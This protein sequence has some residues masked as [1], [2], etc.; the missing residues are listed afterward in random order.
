[1]SKFSF[2]SRIAAYFMV[3]TTLLTAG[4]YLV[5]YFVVHQT[6][7]NHL[8][9][10]LSAEAGEITS[11]I[12]ML[13]DRMILTNPYEWS[14][15]EHSQI[16]VNPTFIQLTDTTGKI[17]KKTPNLLDQSIPV[18]NLPENKSYFNDR[19]SGSPVRQLQVNLTN[20]ARKQFGTLTVAVPLEDSLLVLKNLRNTL[21]LSLPLVIFI[22]FFFTRFIAEKSIAPVNHLTTTAEKITRENLN[23]RI[24]LPVN[25][26][27]LYT[28]TKTINE[29]LDR[30]QDAVLREKQF[31]ADA[32]HELKTPLA[33]IRGMIEVMLRKPR[34]NEYY[35]NKIGYCLHEVN[36][37][38]TLVEQLLI[39]ARYESGAGA[40][41]RENIP[42]SELLDN[43]T[44]EF[45][46]Q[47]DANNLSLLLNIP[48]DTVLSADRFMLE[49]IF[50]NLIS[51][52]IKYSLPGGNIVLN[53]THK[54]EV[55][56]VE[57]TDQGIGM[58]EGQID[59]IFDRF[60]R[61]DV[62][63]SSKISGSGLGLSIV[64]RFADRLGIKLQFKS[65]P[66][67]GTSVTLTFS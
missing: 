41:N 36:R 18:K 21:L 24:D 67:S 63:R 20:H 27:E 61:A 43:L 32:S 10:D 2:S 1:M 60:Y 31:T 5:I 55:T 12:V 30:L 52:A 15:N 64:K 39:L 11:S 37:I 34:D 59:K 42:V 65:A 51:N 62:S 13:S 17:L 8:D 44:K 9:E 57:I 28:L 58:S 66:G 7:Y 19:L 6:V 16:E 3:A 46:D 53:A 14:E 56:L 35:Q 33:S 54:K 45:D 47:L 38:S 40:M 49:Q 4:L 29:L 50:R 26:D 22:I 25:K 48:E 23:D